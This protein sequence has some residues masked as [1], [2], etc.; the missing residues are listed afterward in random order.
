MWY[1]IFMIF[2]AL[3]FGAGIMFEKIAEADVAENE[4]DVPDG[5]IDPELY[6]QWE[7]LFGYDGTVQEDVNDEE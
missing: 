1:L 6:R 2:G 4:E 7:N 5:E 3:I